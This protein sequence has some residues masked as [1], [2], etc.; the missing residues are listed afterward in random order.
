MAH[1]SQP[2]K[3]SLAQLIGR[4]LLVLVPLAIAL[5]FG[6]L[7]LQLRDKVRDQETVARFGVAV[8]AKIER[9][10]IR[11]ISQSSGPADKIA[12]APRQVCQASFRYSP[13]R[14]NAVITKNLLAAPMDICK[15]YKAGDTTKVWVVPADNRI[16]MLEGDRIAPYWSWVSLLLFLV[17]GGFAIIMFKNVLGISRRQA[18]LR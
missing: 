7:H 5:G 3:R 13:P 2:E 9:I 11:K 6:Y 15:R 17:F 18:G 1:A 12:K 10:E 14:G 8:Q 4:S 16:F